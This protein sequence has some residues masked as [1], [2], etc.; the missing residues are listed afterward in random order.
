MG[1]SG[2]GDTG[3]RRKRRKGKTVGE[4]ITDR[5][6]PPVRK[7]KEKKKRKKKKGRG[8]AGLPAG[9]LTRVGPDRLLHLFFCF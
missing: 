6:G 1:A 8:A 5:W 3:S 9:L 4:E 7:K 2:G